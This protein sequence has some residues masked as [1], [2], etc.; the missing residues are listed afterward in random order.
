[1]FIELLNYATK[2][3][4]SEAAHL[5][6]AEAAHRVGV[7]SLPGFR[8]RMLCG[9]GEPGQWIDMVFWTD[10]N[11][12]DAAAPAATNDPGAMAWAT[13]IESDTIHLQTAELLGGYRK[14]DFRLDA[15]GCWS[16]L[17]WFTHPG[18]AVEDHITLIRAAQAQ[19]LPAL[20]GFVSCATARHPATG[21]FFEFVAWRDLDAAK[22]GLPAFEDAC[23]RHPRLQIVLHQRDKRR[24]KQAFLVAKRRL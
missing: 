17:T 4:V 15:T 10:Q 22:K 13:S 24:V 19:L 9:A 18:V 8:D 1:M 20:D 6:D 5:R 12:Y 16:L 11:S 14:E 7:K 2:P 23:N 3:N 21:E